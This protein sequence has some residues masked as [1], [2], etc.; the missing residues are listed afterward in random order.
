MAS[1]YP[2]HNPFGEREDNQQYEYYAEYG[3][4]ENEVTLD[5]D[6]NNYGQETETTNSGGFTMSD[7]RV[8]ANAQ[9]NQNAAPGL[10]INKPADLQA[11]VP[12]PVKQNTL[13]AHTNPFGNRRAPPLPTQAPG[14]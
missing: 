12:P 3:E 1:N 10:V 14:R 9:S 13:R 2:V 6:Q 5:M 4:E 7:N 11:E 8:E